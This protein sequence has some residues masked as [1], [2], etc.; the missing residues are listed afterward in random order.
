VTRIEDDDSIA[1]YIG[2]P[3]PVNPTIV[4]WRTEDGSHM[5]FQFREYGAVIEMN[6][7]TVIWKD[8]RNVSPQAVAAPAVLQVPGHVAGRLSS[9]KGLL[10]HGT[11]SGAAGNSTAQ[12]FDGTVNYVQNGTDGTVGWHCT[13]GDNEIALHMKPDQYGWNARAASDHYLA[14][15][16]AQATVDK[17][18]SNAQ[19]DAFCWWVQ[20]EVL[21]VFPALP[22][23]LKTHAEV[24]DSGETGANDGK[25]DVY[26]TGDARA[27][28]VKARIRARL[29]W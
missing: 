11:R 24:E 19:V 9:P 21:P 23:V 17:P 12:E 13:V 15:E 16:F 10:L 28:D 27:E 20:H 4:S 18:I 14:A 8:E 5:R 29:G 2:Q 1:A 25:S 3:W 22:H 7:E 6:E 26:P